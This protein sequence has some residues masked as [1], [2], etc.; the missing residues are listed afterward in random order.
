MIVDG[1][2]SGLGLELMSEILPGQLLSL[3]K[4]TGFSH[5][6]FWVSLCMGFVWNIS[7]VHYELLNLLLPNLAWWCTFMSWSVM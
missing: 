1:S 4:Q 5:L 6:E 7:Y 3:R 2:A